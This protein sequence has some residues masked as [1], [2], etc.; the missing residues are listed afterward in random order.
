[1]SDQRYFD[2]ARTMFQ[3]Q[4]WTDFMGEL[5]KAYHDR[6]MTYD[7]TENSND[8]FRTQG[9]RQALAWISNYEMLVKQ[10]EEQAD[11]EA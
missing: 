2:D 6:G 4:G 10:A 7:T 8:V 3:T 11:E 1:M 9:F 5:E